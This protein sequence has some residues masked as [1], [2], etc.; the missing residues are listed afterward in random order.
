MFDVLNR[1]RFALM[2]TKTD[3]QGLMM[4]APS[5]VERKELGELNIICTK[6]E[7]DSAE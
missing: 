7:E 5:F 3:A 4:G 6:K 2:P 1:C